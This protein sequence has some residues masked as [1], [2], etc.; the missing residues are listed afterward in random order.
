MRIL[1]KSL[2][3]KLGFSGFN[4]SGSKFCAKL[5]LYVSNPCLSIIFRT[6]WHSLAQFGTNSH[7]F[8]SSIFIAII[9]SKV[10]LLGTVQHWVVNGKCPIHRA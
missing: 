9:E 2:N 10:E 4:P 1:T 7:E 3:D 8:P 6:Y 5:C